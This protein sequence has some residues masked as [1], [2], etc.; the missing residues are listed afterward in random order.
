MKRFLTLAMIVLVL[1]PKLSIA[2]SPFV[3]KGEISFPIGIAALSM[4]GAERQLNAKRQMKSVVFIES[5]KAEQ[6]NKFDRSATRQYSKSARYVSDGMLVTSVL[7]PLPLLADPKIRKDY[8][9]VALMDVEVFLLNAALTNLVK[10]AVSRPR[11]LVYNPEIPI[12]QK[13]AKDNFNSFFSGHT[14]MASSQ[15]FFMATVFTMYNPKNKFLPLVWTAAVS[16]PLTMG[17]MRFKAGKHFWTDILTGYAVGAIVGA[18]V[19][20]LHSAKLWDKK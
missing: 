1:L 2:Q 12:Y 4:F 9:K 15:A 20:L 11:P 3:L 16:F 17:V 19:P 7:L 13:R 5:L 18:G 14:S 6:V 10:T 8:G